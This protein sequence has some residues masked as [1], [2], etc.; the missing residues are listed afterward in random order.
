MK[1]APPPYITNLDGLLDLCLHPD[2]LAGYLTQLKQTQDAIGEQLGILNTKEK[3]DQYLAETT[4]KRE[5]A[6][7]LAQDAEEILEKIKRDEAAATAALSEAKAKWQAVQAEQHRKIEEQ[8][9][10]QSERE[11]RLALESADLI[12]RE[13]HVKATQAAVAS[14]Q[15]SLDV[16][17][18][19]MMKRKALL[20]DLA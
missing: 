9:K 19:K 6:I 1:I 16:E 12:A 14:R 10:S 15:A 17:F 4:A 20:S 11:H 2:K 5:D 3:A 8:A 7:E 13:A 18:D